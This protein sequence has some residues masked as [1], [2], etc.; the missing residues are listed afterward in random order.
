MASNYVR[1]PACLLKTG[2]DCLAQ[3]RIAI[4]REFLRATDDESD[5]ELSGDASWT[6]PFINMKRRFHASESSA[7]REEI[8]CLN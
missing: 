3:S 6:E 2:A 1:V 4:L 8:S 5:P 7:E